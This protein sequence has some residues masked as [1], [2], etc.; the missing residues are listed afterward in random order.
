MVSR[1]S[2]ASSDEEWRPVLGYEGR[3]EVSSLGKVRSLD[4]AYVDKRGVTQH[5]RGRVLS[6]SPKS[7]G[8]LQVRLSR[9]GVQDSPNVHVL[10][11]E[12]F[13]GPRPEGLHVCH[14]DG[15]QKNN[16]VENLRYGTPSSNLMD[17]QEHGTNWARNKTSCPRGHLLSFPNLSDS[18]IRKRGRRACKACRRAA[19]VKYSRKVKQGTI[20]TDAE[21]EAY[22]DIQYMKI[23]EAA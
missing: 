14:N 11:A 10:V 15:N 20:L 7:T 23:M 6:Q 3:Y 22:A 9:S 4:I 13:I 18:E 2:S 19:S 16:R 21:V 8:Y 5:Y 1:L 12:S 17:T